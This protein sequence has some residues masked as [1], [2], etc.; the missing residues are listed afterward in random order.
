MGEMDSTMDDATAEVRVNWPVGDRPIQVSEP[1]SFIETKMRR[2][3]I[4]AQ[5]MAG[6]RLDIPAGTAVRLSPSE[7][8]TVKL[9]EIAGKKSRYAEIIG[10]WT[11]FRRW[12]KNCA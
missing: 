10:E 11:R 8:K 4:A 2:N 3:S 7:T 1:L 5:L 12:E 9:V 6:K